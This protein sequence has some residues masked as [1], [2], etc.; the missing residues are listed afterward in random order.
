MK[1]QTH[2][3]IWLSDLHLGTRDANIDFLF[4]FLKKN[5][6]QYLYLVGD[7]F[8][9]WKVGRGWFWPS[10]K[11]DIVD[12]VLDKAKNG[13]KVFY[14]PG[15][16]DAMF[17]KYAGCEINGVQV[18]AEA[19][20]TTADGRRFLVLH[21]DEFD[22]ISTYSRWLAK[23]GSDAYQILLYLNR[24]LNIFRAK[25]GRSYWS[26]SAFLKHKVKE[27]V[28]FIGNFKKEIVRQ[29]RKRKV[30]GLICGHVHHASFDAFEGVLYTNTGDWVESCTA[31]VESAEGHLRILHWADEQKVLFDERDLVPSAQESY[32]NCY[33]NGRL[34]PTG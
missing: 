2:R 4:D 18:M 27:A 23:L 31:L 5:D 22:L 28:N 26:L 24:Y 8:D 9:L 12:L 17:R 16:H 21:G 11:N 25:T 30:N 20:H 32:E 14:I 34:A 29:A 33:S 10:M 15:N 13:T 7:I 1:T 3:A 19:V 6:A